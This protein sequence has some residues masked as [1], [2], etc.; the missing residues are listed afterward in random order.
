MPGPK[1]QLAYFRYARLLVRRATMGLETAEKWQLLGK[2]LS[3]VRR[4]STR[5]NV[6]RGETETGCD[7]RDPTQARAPGSR[8]P[9]GLMHYGADG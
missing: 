4:I 1:L 5:R 3:T 2:A 8:I 6:E 7:D 9:T